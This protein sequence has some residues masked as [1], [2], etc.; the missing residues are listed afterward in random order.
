MPESRRGTPDERA[1]AV[2]FGPLLALRARLIWRV[3]ETNRAKRISRGRAGSV[4]IY[5]C[6]AWSAG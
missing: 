6:R 4:R 5:D 1:V 2:P 3:K